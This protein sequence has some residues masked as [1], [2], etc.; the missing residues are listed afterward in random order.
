MGMNL[1][2]LSIAGLGFVVIFLTGCV[3]RRLGQP[4]S[5]P[6]LTVHK[7]FAVATIVFLV[8]VAL[9]AGRIAPLGRVA[10]NPRA[11]PPP[12]FSCWRS[13]PAAGWPRS[14]TCR[15]RSACCTSSCLS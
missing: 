8:K 12:F 3:L 6:L 5:V 4:F 9:R 10:W 13:L 2:D 15:P 14:K 1:L 11:S 7:L